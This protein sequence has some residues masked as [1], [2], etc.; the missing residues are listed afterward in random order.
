M[1]IEFLN[2]L[3][4][5]R[6]YILSDH[7]HRRNDKLVMLT[8]EADQEERYDGICLQTELC[9]AGYGRNGR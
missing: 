8:L 4:L 2:V 9:K 5:D 3:T 1:Q 7:G 6:N